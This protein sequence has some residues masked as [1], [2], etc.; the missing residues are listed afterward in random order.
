MSNLHLAASYGEV[1]VRTVQHHCW[2]CHLPTLCTRF[3]AQE[4]RLCSPHLRHPVLWL[5]VIQPG[6]YSMA[7][8]NHV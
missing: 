5:S 2:A 6:L 7:A 1:A 4:A 8:T 3:R